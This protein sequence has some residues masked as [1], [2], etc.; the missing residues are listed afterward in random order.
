[1]AGLLGVG[2][3]CFAEFVGEEVCGLPQVVGEGKL[4]TLFTLAILVFFL[5][6]TV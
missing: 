1:V 6:F 2:P 4:F 5:D 3:G